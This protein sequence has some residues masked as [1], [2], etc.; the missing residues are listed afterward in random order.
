M[1]HAC[2]ILLCS[3]VQYIWMSCR[4]GAKSASPLPP[5]I[6]ENQPP[7]QPS[8]SPSDETRKHGPE[9]IEEARGPGPWLSIVIINVFFPFPQ[10]AIVELI[11]LATFL[12]SRFLS[13]PGRRFLNATCPRMRSMPVGSPG[14]YCGTVGEERGPHHPADPRPTIHEGPS[15]VLRPA[16]HM[17][18]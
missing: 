14:G 15:T 8:Q 10:S 1:R 3:T 13:P 16:S 17:A 9:R 7:F 4:D 12:P 18:S 2:I 5:S 11:L 6:Q